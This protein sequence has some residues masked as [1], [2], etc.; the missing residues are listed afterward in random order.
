MTRHM[1]GLFSGQPGARSWRR[2]LTVEAA[3][4]GAGLEV[5]DQALSAVASAQTQ[6]ETFLSHA[7]L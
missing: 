1:L 3:R 7:L 5:I 6:A 2:I 4:P